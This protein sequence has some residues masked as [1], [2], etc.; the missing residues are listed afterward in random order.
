ML[1][2]LALAGSVEVNGEETSDF[3]FNPGVRY[4][5]WVTKDQQGL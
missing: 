3:T 1:L 2:M 5:Q 4:S